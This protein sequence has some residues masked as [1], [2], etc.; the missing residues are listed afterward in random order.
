MKVSK[1]Q[2]ASNLPNNSIEA[3]LLVTQTEANARREIALSSKRQELEETKIMH[4]VEE[5]NEKL[6]L[7]EILDELQNKGSER[8]KHQIEHFSQSIPDTSN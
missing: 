5:A 4:S 6:T 7:T 2:S 3:K 8:S 1:K